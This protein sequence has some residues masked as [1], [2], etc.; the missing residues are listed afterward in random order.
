LAEYERGIDESIHEEAL[1]VSKSLLSL[2]LLLLLFLL[3]CV[4][5]DAFLC[6]FWDLSAHNCVD[7]FLISDILK[8]LS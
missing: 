7:T 1:L 3:S 6:S 4:D 2:S 8:F 5:A